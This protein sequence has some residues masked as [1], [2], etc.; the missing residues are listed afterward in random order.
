MPVNETLRRYLSKKQIEMVFLINTP[1][2]DV[3]NRGMQWDPNEIEI[4][5]TVNV[6]ACFQDVEDES[7]TLENGQRP[8]CDRVDIDN[9][10]LFS[11]QIAYLSVGPSFRQ[12]AYVLLSIQERSG[13]PNLGACTASMISK[14]VRTACDV[15][16]WNVCE[17]L[18]EAW[19][20]SVALDVFTD[21]SA[22]YLDIWA[23]LNLNRHDIVSVHL[24]AVSI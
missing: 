11:L 22:L 8:D 14:Y 6:N 13:L 9:C 15:N 20:S 1:I 17:L 3:L 23:R 24:L 12:A 19:T 5:T 21:V 10:M 7:E 2:V 18:A 4:Q 16:F